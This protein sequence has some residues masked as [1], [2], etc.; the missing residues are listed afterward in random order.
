MSNGMP[1][2]HQAVDRI[3]PSVDDDGVAVVLEELVLQ[4]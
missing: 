1:L 2:A 3:A 4:D